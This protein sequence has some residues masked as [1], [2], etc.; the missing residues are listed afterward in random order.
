MED[1]GRGTDKV[2]YIVSVEDH[3]LE[4]VC[5]NDKDEVESRIGANH[6]FN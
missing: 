6:F 5:D 3:A 2:G 1:P 4:K